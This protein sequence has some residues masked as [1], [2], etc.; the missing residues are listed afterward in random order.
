MIAVA[1]QPFHDEASDTAL[2]E[3][4]RET[5]EPHVEVHERE[6]EIN[7]PAFAH[8]MAERLHELIGAAA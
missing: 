7:D 8:A 1:G 5:L 6:E 2:R 3:G 4:L